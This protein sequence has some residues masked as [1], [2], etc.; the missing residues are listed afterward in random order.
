MHDLWFWS[1][2]RRHCAR[3][4]ASQGVLGPRS[5]PHCLQPLLAN[6]SMLLA[7]YDSITWVVLLE[8]GRTDDARV[9]ELLQRRAIFV[10]DV[11]TQAGGHGQRLSGDKFE[12]QVL[13]LE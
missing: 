7:H 10:D 6:F 2:S 11:R 3:H 4:A 1:A 5:F 13:E 8:R 9:F 12:V